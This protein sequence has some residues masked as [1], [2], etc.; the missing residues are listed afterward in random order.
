MVFVKVELVIEINGGLIGFADIAG[1]IRA[2]L[3]FGEEMVAIRGTFRDDMKMNFFELAVWGLR[4]MTA[5]M[6]NYCVK[7]V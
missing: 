1:H 4:W 3:D 2:R 6:P 7:E 5:V